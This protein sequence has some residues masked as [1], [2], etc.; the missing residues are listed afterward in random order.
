MR[1][2]RRRRL[3]ILGLVLVLLGAVAAACGTSKPADRV[4]ILTWD[5][6]VNPVMA[7]YVERGI[8]T[9]EKS[10]ARAVV[11]RL[12]TP[13]GLDSA[14]RDIVQSI[15][16]TRVPVIV[17]VSPSGGRAASAGTF[18]TMAGH[19]A[20]MAPNT[21]IGAATPIN[22]DGEDIE[23]ALGRK[24]TND[25][26]AYIR[27]IAELRGRNA[28]WAE[29]AV[30]DAVAIGQTEAV[31]IKVVD[32]VAVGLDDLL[33]QSDGRSV[34]VRSDG[35]SVRNVT[36]RTAG[37]GTVENNPT[38]LERLLDIIATPDI[39]YLLLTLGGLALVVEIFHPSGLT[40]VFGVTALVL[41]FFSLG[42][43]PTNWAGVALVGFGFALLIAEVFVSGFGVLGIGGVIALFFGGLL[44]TGSSETGYQ[45]SR[46]LVVGI[47][48]TIG[49]LILVFAAALL[50]M[51]RMPPHSGK[52]SLI[53]SKGTA[54][55]ALSPRGVVLVAGERWD[56]TAE[57][58]PLPEDTPV[59]V[60]A[61]EGLRLRVRRDPDSIKLL[62]AASAGA[63][64]S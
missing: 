25:A 45:V 8:A 24:V 41:A 64:V 20:A 1:I 42:A 14:M 28:D 17:Y 11:L 63:E 22:Q 26:V 46:W 31:E 9:A 40:G 32:F 33:R 23:G 30:R 59:V 13:G 39:A 21:T 49:V 38:L 29:K 36:L 7:R 56:A 35:D 16:S 6:D 18:I 44:L 2:L 37:A 10:Q 62:P 58:G 53:G 19:V 47:T 12:D 50:R 60:T 5:G 57:D 61:T 48:G 34:E 3:G 52:E 43:L 51:R 4:H 54:R 27:G 55:T 15:E